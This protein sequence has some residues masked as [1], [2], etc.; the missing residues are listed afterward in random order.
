MGL[1]RL[2]EEQDADYIGKQALHELQQKGVDRK[3]VGISFAGEGQ[4]LTL[5]QPWPVL[6]D[7]RPVGRVT[8]VTWSP[9]LERNIGYVWV[10]IELASPGHVLDVE[11]EQGS[12]QGTTAAIPFIDPHKRAPAAPLAS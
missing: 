7:G 9:A 11:S 12:L 2:V 4:D 10:P 6:R 1:E 8:D 5:T 3:L